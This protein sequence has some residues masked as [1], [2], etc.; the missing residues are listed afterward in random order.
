MSKNS[1]HSKSSSATLKQT[2]GANHISIRA[3]KRREAPLPDPAEMQAYKEIDPLLPLEIMGMA[4]AEQAQRHQKENY[5]LQQAF[6]TNIRNNVF[7]LLGVVII[8][9]TGL[10]FLFKGEAG[11]GSAIIIACSVSMAGVF[12]VRRLTTK[13]GSDTQQPVS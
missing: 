11:N 1:R 10:A 2:Q 7:A 6:R 12:I 4:K 8:C 5:I 3:E 9:A 13:S